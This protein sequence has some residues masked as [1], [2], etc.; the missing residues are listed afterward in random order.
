MPARTPTWSADWWANTRGPRS[1]AITATSPPVGTCRAQAALAA[2]FEQHV[3]G[4]QWLDQTWGEQAA[5]GTVGLRIPIDRLTLKVKMSQDK[6]PVSVQQVIDALR[7][8]GP[9]QHDSLADNMERARDEGIGCGSE[10]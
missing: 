1:S 4:P 7:R 9:Y 8:D 10:N 5:R 3:D 6:D 2:H